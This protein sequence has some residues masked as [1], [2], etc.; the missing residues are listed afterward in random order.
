[1]ASEVEWS[2]ADEDGGQRIPEA[3]WS[4]VDTIDVAAELRDLVAFDST[5]VIVG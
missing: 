1:V 3:A 2:E 5:K 4:N